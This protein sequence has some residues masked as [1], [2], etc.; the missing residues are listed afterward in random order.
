LKT[1]EFKESGIL[2]AHL[3]GLTN[4]EEQKQVREMVESDRALEEYVAELEA[5]IN[6][7][8]SK[9]SVDPPEAVREVVKLRS[10]RDKKE[11]QDFSTKQN[12]RQYLDVEVNDTHIKVHKN[13]RPLFIAVF[14]LSKIFLIAGLYYYFKSASQEEELQKLKTQ[15]EQTK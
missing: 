13:W 4:R 6:S 14:I 12:E 7:Y 3:L 2:E 10:V 8:F 5:G 1:Q 11:Q 9:E 15:I